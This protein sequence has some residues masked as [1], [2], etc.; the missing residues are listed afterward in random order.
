MS[1]KWDGASK[2]LLPDWDN[3]PAGTT[4]FDMAKRCFIRGGKDESD[5]AF[6]WDDQ[7]GRWVL[8]G[9]RTWELKN[10][11]QIRYCKRPVSLAKDSQPPT[12]A[13][14]L[15]SKSAEEK[16]V[17]IDKETLS[18]LIEYPLKGWER[19]SEARDALHKR[20]AEV[21]TVCA[22]QRG[23]LGAMLVLLITMLILLVCSWIGR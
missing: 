1:I 23:L 11:Y 21:E 9:A 4:H 8:C 10:G 6:A 16:A 20:L 3:A 2:H 22:L 12:F 19:A 17:S 7:D 13:V 14:P 18:S 5:W 15:E